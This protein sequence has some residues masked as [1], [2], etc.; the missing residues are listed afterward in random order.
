MNKKR[1]S[2]STILRAGDRAKQLLTRGLGTPIT[3]G[4]ILPWWT[5]QKGISIPSYSVGSDSL[6]FIVWRT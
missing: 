2:D 3:L 1:I 4:M 5:L 6:Y